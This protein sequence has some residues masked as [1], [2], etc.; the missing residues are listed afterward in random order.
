MLC[1][2]LPQEEE[3]KSFLANVEQTM[4]SLSASVESREQVLTMIAAALD[5]CCAV[6]ALCLRGV[7]WH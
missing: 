3:K 6:S 5:S 2:W 1:V 4:A 7:Q